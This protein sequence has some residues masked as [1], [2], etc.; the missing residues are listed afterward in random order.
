MQK[1]HL[2]AGHLLRLDR[3]R[4]EPRP[5]RRPVQRPPAIG[6][7]PASQGP[8]AAADRHRPGAGRRHPHRPARDAVPR[9]HGP[10]RRS[11]APPTR[12]RPPRS[13]A[14]SC[15]R[16][17][18]TPTSRRSAT[19]TSTRSTPS[20][21]RAR[22]PR[23]PTLAAELVAA[24]VAGYQRDG[25]VSSSAKHFPG[26]GDTATDSHVAFP[27]IT[28]TRAQWEAIDAPPFRA[29]IDAADRHDHDGPPRLPG[30]GRLR[31]PRH[32][33]QADHDRRAARGARLRRR[34][35]HGLP[36][37]AGRA[38]PLR[39]RRGGRARPAGR[40]R[41]AAHDP[42][43][44]RGVCRGAR[45]PCAAAA[46]A[47]RSSTRRCVACCGSST[48]AASSPQ[49][50]R[51]PAP[52]RPPSSALRANLAAAASVTDRTTTLVKNDDEVLPM[53]A[54]RQEGARHRLRR[55]HDGDPRG[56][57]DRPGRDGPD[58]P[59]RHAPPPTP[60]VARAVAAAAGKDVVVVTTMKAWDTAVTDTR[61]RPADSSSSSCSP[62]A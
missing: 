22:S 29:A 35:R 5:D 28:H 42:G 46:S 57:P 51:R 36:R 59:D 3:Q 10:G 27:I 43:H 14:A 47:R 19:S 55:L 30:A 61:R 48:A 58:G 26:H 1:Y 25:G 8:R 11:T 62:P 7:D 33:E 52:G 9:V 12:A 56:R 45:P 18:S 13:P 24:Q 23:T 6:A 38:R 41:P 50:Y 54:E 49:P 32:P 53:A 44:G 39:R 15:S 21:A 20:S 40:R 17:V 2:G 34:H 4:A 31:R 16:W 60:L 37:H